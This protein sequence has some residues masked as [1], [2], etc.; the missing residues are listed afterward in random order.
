MIYI[1]YSNLLICIVSLV[2]HIIFICICNKLQTIVSKT[3]PNHFNCK[4]LYDLYN[5][6]ML[7]I[8]WLCSIT[9]IFSLF[10]YLT[11]KLLSISSMQLA[12]SCN[13]RSKL[14]YVSA[15]HLQATNEIICNLRVLNMTPYM[16]YIFHGILLNLIAT[17]CIQL[18]QRCCT[19]VFRKKLFHIQSYIVASSLDV[20]DDKYYDIYYEFTYPQIC[21]NILQ[22]Q[23]IY[24]LYTTVFCKYIYIYIYIYINYI[25]IIYIFILYIYII[26]IYNLKT[27]VVC[28]WNTF[29][30]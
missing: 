16:K 4:T 7:Q 14:Y 15:L 18:W 1:V 21:T 26:Y 28:H 19:Y 23:A 9:L 2:S 10:Y 22:I 8:H 12:V 24:P 11:Y 27:L 13:L 25:Y 6:T 20:L 30:C 29:T 17:N 3:F 5:R